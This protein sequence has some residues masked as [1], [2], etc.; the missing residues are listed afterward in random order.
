M[1]DERFERAIS[2]LHNTATTPPLVTDEYLASL[3]KRTRRPY[4]AMGVVCVLLITVVVVLNRQPSVPNITPYVLH[5]PSA[6]T[7]ASALQQGSVEHEPPENTSVSRS[8]APQR[9]INTHAF[10]NTNWLPT[11]TLDAGHAGVSYLQLDSTELQRLGITVFRDSVVVQ[12]VYGTA[13][14]ATSE[15]DSGMYVSGEVLHAHYDSIIMATV[16]ISPTF[17]KF[18]IRRASPVQF[19]RYQGL[20]CIAEQDPPL[21]APLWNTVFQNELASSDTVWMVRHPRTTALMLR[22]VKALSWKYQR[23]TSD[24]L[25]MLVVEDGAVRIP[26]AKLLVPVRV[27]TPWTA[28]PTDEKKRIRYDAILWYLPSDRF[29][30]TLPKAVRDFVT[31]EY[32]AIAD[33]IELRLTM[34]ETCERLAQP[35]ALGL[36]SDTATP[37]SILSVGPIPA[38]DHVNLFVNSSVS[39]PI[40]VSFIDAN[41]IA[42]VAHDAT[43]VEEG[44]SSIEVNLHELALPPGPYVILIECVGHTI[45]SRALI[46]R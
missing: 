9:M 41:G 13:L 40:T 32:R 10:L 12:T 20:N 43:H 21:A 22:V 5:S 8:E 11:M 35:S 18:P 36:C 39:A 37:L 44:R 24:S 19:E 1:T 3:K 42:H 2:N 17:T 29:L 38:Q 4:F 34:Q 46:V 16:L 25:M 26:V 28:D 15:R 23:M 27:A 14:S 7:A 6:Q 31:E 33:M 45:S 30:A